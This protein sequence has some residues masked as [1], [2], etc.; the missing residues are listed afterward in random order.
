MNTFLSSFADKATKTVKNWWL[1]LVC[2]LL[3]IAAGIVVFCNPVS[4]Y[5]TLSLLFGVVFIV[6]GV[7]ELVASLTSR[8]FFMMRGYNIAGGVL[9]ILIGVLLC[10]TPGLDMVLLP[11]FLGVWV[12]YHSFMILGL[13]GDFRT[14][15]VGGAGW[16][17]FIGIV[18][19]L[20]SLLIIFKPFSF[21]T[22]AVVILTG[23]GL[24]VVGFTMISASLRLRRI[25]KTVKDYLSIDEQ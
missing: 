25:H 13:A 8:N 11:I 14:L 24:I 20:L 4:S 21:G 2:G 18:M 9:D 16:G 15:G 5:I 17:I 12:L 22:S 3:C 1:F 10:A 23:V 6:S 7:L 19:L